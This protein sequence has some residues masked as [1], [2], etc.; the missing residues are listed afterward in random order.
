MITSLLHLSTEEMEARI[1]SGIR[2]S[3]EG[4]ADDYA[5]IIEELEPLM[6]Y[7]E[8]LKSELIRRIKARGDAGTLV[9][10]TIDYGRLTVS[11]RK[12]S[13]RVT[14]D[15]AGLD[16]Y[17][18]ANPDVLKFRKETPVKSGATVKVKK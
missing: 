6:A 7:A 14:Y 3:S 8:T 13:T 16:G 2:Q 18:V 17:A 4:V 1:E 9:K 11:Y 15:R 12:A 5:D 10:N